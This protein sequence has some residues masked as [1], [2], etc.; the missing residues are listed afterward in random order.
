MDAN[1]FKVKQFSVFT[2]DKKNIV[3]HISAM[4]SLY[5]VLYLSFSENSISIFQSGKSEKV[6][7]FIAFS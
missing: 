1:S 5:L 3:C 4:H 7:Q 2:L 6:F